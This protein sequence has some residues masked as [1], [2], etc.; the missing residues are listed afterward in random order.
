MLLVLDEGHYVPDVARDALEVD[1]EI[2]LVQLTAQVDNFIQH[3][4]QYIGQF[5]P[6]K[7]PKL[8]NPE[9]LQQHAENYGNFP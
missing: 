9:R 5:R 7:P 1:G 2:T 6:V 8:A 3:V 4:G